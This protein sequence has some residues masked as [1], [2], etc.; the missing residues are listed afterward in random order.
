MKINF[1]S[2]ET[3]HTL[4]DLDVQRCADQSHESGVEVDS[5]VIGHR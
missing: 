3:F 5:V 4:G 2:F 1:W